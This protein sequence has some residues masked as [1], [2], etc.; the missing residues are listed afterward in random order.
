MQRHATQ[1]SLSEKL[2]STPAADR[3]VRYRPGLF[4][5]IDF[6]I[7]WI[8]LWTFVIGMRQGWL[9][10]GLPFMILAGTSA[11]I[12]AAVFVHSTGS[13]RFI[14]SF[15][16][17][18]FDPRR[19]G[20][21]WWLFI[22]LFHICINVL[23]IFISL[24]FNGSPEQFAVSQRVI[25]APVLFLLMTMV[26]GPLPEELGWR[27]YGLDALR[28][29]MNLLKASM[30]LG[31]FWGLWHLPL[32]FM[33]GSFQRGLLEHPPAFFAYLFAFFPTSIIMS[34][35]YYRNRRSTLSAIMI[36]FFGNM[37][38]ELFSLPLETRVYQA[39]LT[40]LLAACILWK[41]WTMFSQR[42]FWVQDVYPAPTAR[43]AA[44]QPTAPLPAAEQQENNSAPQLSSRLS[45]TGR[46]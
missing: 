39:L 22:L 27:G 24:L 20:L 32:Y 4:F 46:G 8:P 25:E 38:G 10:F 36:H 26:Y 31:S 15:W 40:G 43:Q 11:T 12:L 41:D 14:R 23:A 1:P 2:Q 19:V 37:S 3:A 45:R 28:S 9:D 34:W 18:A 16:Q 44:P 17:R 7:T 21:H 29:R 13:R 30:L 6:L 35:V 33:P 5:G 42:E